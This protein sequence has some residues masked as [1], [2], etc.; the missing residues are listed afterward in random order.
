MR[1]FFF[2]RVFSLKMIQTKRIFFS[3]HRFRNVSFVSVSL[4]VFWSVGHHYHH[5]LIESICLATAFQFLFIP[6]HIISPKREKEKMLAILVFV[7]MCI[8]LNLAAATASSNCIW[9]WKRNLFHFYFRTK[10]QRNK[11]WL[12]CHFTATLYTSFL[13]AFFRVHHG[14]FFSSEALTNTVARF[15]LGIIIINN[16][17]QCTSAANL[18]AQWV[19]FS[20]SQFWT[21]VCLITMFCLV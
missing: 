21:P 13:H 18:L 2:A 7:C 15:A 8:Y 9:C 1:S 4:N 16:F 6:H 12:S 10:T 5:H 3:S 17:G 19:L 14:F 20:M 11:C